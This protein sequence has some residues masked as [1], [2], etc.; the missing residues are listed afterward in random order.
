[1]DLTEVTVER[2]R[3]AKATLLQ[4]LIDETGRA[5]GKDAHFLGQ[6]IEI[7]KRDGEPN[8]DANCGIVGPPITKAFAIALNKV[9]AQYNLD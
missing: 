9:Q 6:K 7:R 5:L 2:Q 4:I 8:W 3:V 1:L